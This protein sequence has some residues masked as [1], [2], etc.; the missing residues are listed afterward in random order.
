MTAPTMP[1]H[2]LD[3][4]DLDRG[5]LRALLDRAH[6]MKAARV[7]RPASLDVHLERLSGV[8]PLPD[9][10]SLDGRVL[11]MIFEKPS[12]RTRISFDVAMRH[13]GG[14]TLLLNR[15]DLQLGR[16]ES[17]D[18]TARV[19][20]L[21]VDAV[22]LRVLSHST[23][24][25]FAAAATVPVI[26][27][28]T[29]KSHPCQIIADIMTIEEALGGI[30]AGRRVAWVGDANNVATSFVH[31]AA[32]LDFDLC[33]AT[34]PSLAPAPELLAWADA[35]GARIDVSDDA[36]AAV[37][38]ADCVVTDTWVSMGDDDREAR[39]EALTP[40]QVNAELMAHADP[41]A[42]FLHCLPAYRGQEVTGDV[43]DGPQ[44][45]VIAEAENRL[46]AQKA[47]LAWCL[48]DDGT[49]EDAA[50]AQRGAPGSQH[51][52]AG[53]GDAGVGAAG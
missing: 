18:D 38:E 29:D 41:S 37:R 44:S 27:G 45:R 23:L 20:S 42:I 31:A 17:I 13:L 34:P 7:G 30:I 21:Y 39:I 52:H 40:Y 46:H 43:I 12:T 14:E 2:F 3:I 5:E 50:A 8:A 4:V 28:L 53:V 47:I 6:H 35:E 10:P 24:E 1:R 49:E 25:T 36:V 11:A 16:G 19:M 51:A 33:I 26:N 22:M 32:R 15:D 9:A 48:Q